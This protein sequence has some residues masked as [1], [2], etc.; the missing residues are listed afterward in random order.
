MHPGTVFPGPGLGHKGGVKA[1]TLGNGLYRQLKSHNVICR[2]KG[3]VI[4]EINLML[5]GSH[6]VVGGLHFKSHL[7]QGQHHISSGIL[8]LVYRTHIKISRLLVGVGG[9]ISLV[10]R[11]EQ[12]KLTLR[13]YV[14][15]IAHLSRFLKHL[16]QNIAGIALIGRAIGSL[17]VTDQTGHFALLGPPG[18]DC[19]RIQIRGQQ[20]I[21]IVVICKSFDTGTVKHIFPVQHPLQLAGRHGYIFQSSE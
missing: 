10:I 20:K 9:G 8:P 12:E 13:S 15:L 14:K 11:M 7:L 17:D 1:E 3:F 6:L 2:Q 4:P 5:S 19:Q 18:K 16:F 21:R